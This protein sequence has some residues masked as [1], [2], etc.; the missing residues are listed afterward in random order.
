MNPEEK[1]QIVA[2]LHLRM[3]KAKVAIL[4]RFIG[5]NA[6]KMTQL[7]REL[8]KSA[9]EYRI[10]KNTL[11]RLALK[12]TDKEPLGSKL[13]GPIAVAWSEADLITPARVLARFTKDFP[14]LQ[15]LLAS[16]E[17]KLWGP[18]EIQAWVNLPSLEEL[19]ARIVGLILAPATK[20][21]RL[22]ATPGTRIAQVLQ[23]RSKEA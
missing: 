23:A 1:K 13:E 4:T 3:Q 5:L 8:R 19:R 18:A 7:R 15:I 2:D 9:V 17:G 21:A 22:T 16:S 10:V 11:L 14:E 6:G 12:G 20:L